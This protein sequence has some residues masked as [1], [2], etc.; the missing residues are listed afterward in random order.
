MKT[1]PTCQRQFTDEYAFCLYDGTTLVI[2]PDPNMPFGGVTQSFNFCGQCATPMSGDYAFCKKCGASR[3]RFEGQKTIP[4]VAVS[5]NTSTDGETVSSQR[6]W[7]EENKQFAIIL[8]CGIGLSLLIGVLYFAFS[9]GETAASNT[10]N[11]SNA[12]A[13]RAANNSNRSATPVTRANTAPTA[14]QGGGRIGRLTTDLNIRDE[15]NKYAMSL[16]I[17]FRGAKVRILDSTTYETPEGEMVT[18]Y[19]I[20]ILEYGCSAD[21]NL[22]CG[23]NSPN[24]SDEGWLNG[25]YV[26]FD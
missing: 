25:K 9:G 21:Q 3:T 22:G 6:Q 24:D 19:K 23:K 14:N 2:N 1:C 4:A 5:E 16:G 13:N 7:F 10:A 26:L 15:P 18:W 20:Q 8:A 12:N 17:H 11:N